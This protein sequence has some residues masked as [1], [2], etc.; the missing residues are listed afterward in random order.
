MLIPSPCINHSAQHIVSE[1][2]GLTEQLGLREKHRAEV[3][4][5]ELSG[6]ALLGSLGY[7]TL[8]L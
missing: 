2:Q 1:E 4:V 7:I 6:S 5:L 8:P 3:G